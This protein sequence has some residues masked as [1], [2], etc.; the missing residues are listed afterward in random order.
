MP[1]LKKIVAVI[2]AGCILLLSLPAW[3]EAPK[4]NPAS[5]LIIPKDTLVL[6][7]FLNNIDS[8]SNQVGD[9][10]QF[11]TRE[12][13]VIDG[14]TVIP[15]GTRG[16]GSIEE[17]HRAGSWGKG[18]YF[19]ISFGSLK[20]VNGM[21]IPVEIGKAAQGAQRAE[22]VILPVVSLVFCWPL[23]FFGFTKGKEAKIAQGTQ[24]Y[25]NTRN[26]LDLGL[27]AEEA[28]KQY[29]AANPQPAPTP[30]PQATP[31]KSAPVYPTLAVKEL[32]I[33]KELSKTGGPVQPGE[34]FPYGAK[35]LGIYCRFEQPQA[36]LLLESKW[37]CGA[38]LM[39]NKAFYIGEEAK[40]LVGGTVFLSEPFP[41]GDWKVELVLNRQIIKTTAFKIQ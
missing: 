23:A 26:E 21:E 32:L 35:S 10:V 15:Y 38:Q 34:S 19:K 14:V 30:T 16:V 31:E 28:Q 13:L 9:K 39:K 18:G 22:G 4:N 33:C 3:G 41:K 36:N 1:K 25:V 6:V 37:Y 40:E 2:L 5:N 17:V 8:G 12:K 27:T 29:A 11:E 20:A 24:F 7:E